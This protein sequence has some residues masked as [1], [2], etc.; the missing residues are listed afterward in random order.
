MAPLLQTKLKMRREFHS[1]ST[2]VTTLHRNHQPA[3]GC[4]FTTS[5]GNISVLTCC[6]RVPAVR[7]IR[8][9]NDKKNT[10]GLFAH[11]DYSGRVLITINSFR[12]VQGSLIYFVPRTPLIVW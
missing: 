4:I 3:F 6:C 10:L 11:F 12:S 7:T 8:C 5:T 9:K 1:K 2:Y